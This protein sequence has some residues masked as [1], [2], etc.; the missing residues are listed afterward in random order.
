MLADQEKALKDL[1]GEELATQVVARVDTTNKEAGDAAAIVKE[2][3]PADASQTPAGISGTVAEQMAAAINTVVKAAAADAAPA[4]AAKVCVCPECG[5]SAKSTDGKACSTV[6]CS[7]CDVA[8]K[9]KGAKKDDELPAGDVLAILKE[10]QTAI[11][12][13]SAEIAAIKSGDAPRIN[14]DGPPAAPVPV[15]PDVPRPMEVPQVVKSIAAAM[16]RPQS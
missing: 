7:A 13:L 2:G 9:D 8:M 6:K 12:G 10:L 1:L 3:P 4:P 14:R 11:T 15:D 16:F 5:K